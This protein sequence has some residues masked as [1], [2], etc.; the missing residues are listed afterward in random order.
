MLLDTSGRLPEFMLDT[1]PLM[2]GLCDFSG[3]LLM[4]NRSA[5]D[6]AELKAADLKGKNLRDSPWWNPAQKNCEESLALVAQG[7]DLTFAFTRA[8]Q[9]LRLSLRPLRNEERQIQA[10]QFEGEIITEDP[11]VREMNHRFK[12]HLQVISSILYFHSRPGS[13]PGLDSAIHRCQSLVRSIS[14]A[15]K[16]LPTL[17][18]EAR[19]PVGHYLQE[20]AQQMNEERVGNRQL[21]FEIA[22]VDVNLEIAVPLALLLNELLARTLNPGASC[23]RLILAE[24]EKQTLAISIEHNGPNVANQEN[25]PL[26][27]LLTRQIRAKIEQADDRPERLVLIVPLS[28]KEP[29]CQPEF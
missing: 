6:F 15:Y 18:G 23:I 12:N 21:H 26:V 10:I 19:L 28:R 8:Q 14:L 17:D 25:S 24:Q 13:E 3:N 11:R 7:Q 29:P 5:L 4:A 20:L 27:E 22:P 2:V 16:M 9:D 1:L